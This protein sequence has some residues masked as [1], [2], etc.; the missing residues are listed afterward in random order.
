MAVSFAQ[1]CDANRPCLS[2]LPAEPLLVLVPGQDYRRLLSWLLRVPSL[3][4]GIDG[5]LEGVGRSDNLGY[6][7]RR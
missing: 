1:A 4:K 3:C 2:A 6:R 7:N 5:V